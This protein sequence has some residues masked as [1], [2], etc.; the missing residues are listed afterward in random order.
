MGRREAVE[1]LLHRAAHDGVQLVQR[2]VDP[3]V[4][5]A[6]LREVVGADALAAVA[7][8]HHRLARGTHLGM[9]FGLHLLQQPGLQHPHGLVRSAVGAVVVVHNVHRVVGE[10]ALNDVIN[11]KHKKD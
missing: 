5:H 3:M 4:G 7:G 9:G 2:E 11:Q 8:A 6:V 10:N 1:Q